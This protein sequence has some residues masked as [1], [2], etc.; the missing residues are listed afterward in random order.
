MCYAKPGPRCSG[1]AHARLRHFSQKV[2]GLERIQDTLQAIVKTYTEKID[3]LASEGQKPA[4]R[5][6]KKARTA[7]LNDLKNTE[8]LIEVAKEK[9]ADATK[10]RDAT[11]RGQKELREL[12]AKADDN[13][14]PVL[15]E[16]LQA[17]QTLHHKQVEDLNKVTAAKLLAS[18]S[19]P[20]KT[21]YAISSVNTIS[22][23]HNEYRASTIDDSKNSVVSGYVDDSGDVGGEVQLGNA[24]SMRVETF[25]GHAVVYAYTVGCDA[26]GN[27]LDYSNADKATQYRYQ[28][29][30]EHVSY[31]EDD[32]SRQDNDDGGWDFSPY[33]EKDLS[34][35]E[36]STGSAEF[37]YRFSE[38]FFSS[39]E[40]ADRAATKFAKSV[41]VK[42]LRRNG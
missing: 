18:R 4:V 42:S 36:Q 11:L 15:Q 6:L 13:L 31:D 9:L 20:D 5:S 1:H 41:T 37:Y 19:A 7:S 12:I 32:D 26:E 25:D 3:E 34:D 10:E 40:E 23:M 35:D 8:K 16:R 29:Q 28:I 27:V 14:K 39:H 17:G 33:S 21:N 38:E 30:E 2:T 24:H 22:P